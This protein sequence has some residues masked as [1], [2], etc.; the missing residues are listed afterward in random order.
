MT[1]L[2]ELW[3]HFKW[4]SD[5]EAYT[6]EE[7]AFLVRF[8]AEEYRLREQKKREHLLRMS[9]IKR[10]KLLTDFD[11]T[12]NPKIPREKL[13]EFMATDWL[14][15]QCN[16]ILVGPPGVGKSHVVSALCYDAVNKGTQ[17]V[18]VTLFDLTARLTRAK[19]VYSLIEYYARVP[20]LCLDE[21]GY[22]L[23]SREHADYLFQ[24]V[25]KRAEVGTTLV[26]T[27]LVPSQ[28]G[29]MFDSVTASAILD[30]LTMNGTFLT[31]DGKSYRNKKAEGSAHSHG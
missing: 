2:P 23:P 18:F 13:M 8:L 3:K 9:G 5:S 16:L 1:T 26:T 12:F 19:S 10:V 20:V 27:N 30:R 4:L 21:L 29:K 11:W 14:K 28:W 25:S 22:A 24:I 17:T 6:I 7:R 31:F 15:K